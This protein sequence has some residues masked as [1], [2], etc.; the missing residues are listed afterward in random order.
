MIGFFELHTAHS[1]IL[2]TVCV[3][4][5]LQN[6][7]LIKL[8]LACEKQ[9][10][11]V[12]TASDGCSLSA[13]HTLSDLVG[14]QPNSLIINFRKV[15]KPFLVWNIHDI[16]NNCMLLSCHVHIWSLSEQ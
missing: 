11:A 2:L 16:K 13:K 4:Q 12:K 9:N 5:L 6:L 14:Q 8:R 3:D 10:T 1:E 7:S 15:I